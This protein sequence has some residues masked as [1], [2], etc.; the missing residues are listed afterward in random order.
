[1]EAVGD[2]ESVG[3]E[4]DVVLPA[5]MSTLKAI[6]SGG[7]YASSYVGVATYTIAANN[8]TFSPGAGTYSTPQN[9]TISDSTPGVTIYYAFN[10]FPT[11]SSP[12]CSSPCTVNVAT[13]T[14]LRAMALG[15]GISQS[16][17]AVASYTITGH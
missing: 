12:S 3:Q 7:G 8:P 9:V 16:G 1:M 14:V 15:N 11:T 2:C 10:G 4:L 6:A 5:R 13:T 17:T